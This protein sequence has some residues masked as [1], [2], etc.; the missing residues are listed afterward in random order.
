MEH[1]LFRQAA[2]AAFLLL[3]GATRYYYS[4]TAGRQPVDLSGPAG[5]WA[6][7]VPAYLTSIAWTLYVAWRIFSPAQLAAWDR[8]PLDHWMADLL[9]WVA[10]PV[11]ISGFLLFWY[12]HHTIGRYW[13]I[14]IG[15]KQAHQ[16]VTSGPY[17]CIRHPLYSALFLGYLGT[18]LA[19]Q[20]WLLAAWFPLFLASYLIFA[21]EEESIMERSFGVAYQVYRQKTGMFLPTW[22]RIRSSARRALKRQDPRGPGTY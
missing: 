14:R 16:L 22:S 2:C 18:L 20:S 6:R 3:M 17:A 11:L 10:I 8:W 4:L 5:K 7:H 21:K 13:N 9:G 19:L 1:L 12:S 15:M